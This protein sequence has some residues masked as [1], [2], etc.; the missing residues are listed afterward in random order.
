M[1]AEIVHPAASTQNPDNAFLQLYRY[2]AAIDFRPDLF[3]D[4]PSLSIMFKPRFTADSRWWED[5]MA[6]GGRD[7]ETDFLVNEWRIQGRAT[8]TLFLSFGKEKTLWGPSFLAAP[9]NMLFSNT[10]KINPKRELEGKYL[11]KLM[12]IPDNAVTFTVG[13]ETGKEKTGL[14]EQ[15]SVLRFAKADLVGRNYAVSGIGYHRQHD[16][17]RLGSYGQ[18]TASDALVLYYDGLVTKG[19]DALYPEAGAFVKKYENSGKL[20]TVVSAGGSYTFLSG[21]T[22][23]LEF[24]C[25][26]QGYT[27]AEAAEYYRLRQTAADHLFDGLMAGAYRRNTLAEALNAGQPFLRKYYLLAQFQFREI[28]NAGDL[29]VRYLYNLEEHA[30]QASTIVEWRITDRMQFFNINSIAVSHARE[31][32]FR[33]L[34][35]KS[36]MVGIEIHF[37]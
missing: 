4:Q 30:G 36:S 26:G 2:S 14:G 5:G 3:W 13:S 22:M 10:E 25:N 28:R 16:R 19:T 32:E 35:D 37:L 11:A 6:D 24:L 29:S 33:A 34:A 12:F 15:L 1:F 8:S 20:F 18:W 27:D 23:S 17:L 21:S 31:T 9:S 7:A